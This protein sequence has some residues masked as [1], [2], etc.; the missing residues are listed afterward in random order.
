MPAAVASSVKNHNSQ[1]PRVALVARCLALLIERSGNSRTIAPPLALQHRLTAQPVDALRTRDVGVGSVTKPARG[2]TASPLSS[3]ADFSVQAKLA[4]QGLC[5]KS[6]HP[7]LPVQ[8]ETS[9]GKK[10]RFAATILADGKFKLPSPDEIKA[11][12]TPR[13]KRTGS[14]AWDAQTLAEWG[15]PWPPKQGWRN[16]LRRRWERR[17]NH[18]PTSIKPRASGNSCANCRDESLHPSAMIQL[19]RA[20]ESG[21]LLDVLLFCGRECL[22]VWECD[23]PFTH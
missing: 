23:N 22:T 19:T 8:V 21:E 1:R 9:M 7:K 3:S 5:T 20:A 6:H 11:A 18:R 17:N 16:E 13:S 2:A 14:L 15:I 10:M 12:A 4:E